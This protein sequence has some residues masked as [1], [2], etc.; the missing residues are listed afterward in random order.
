ML[1]MRTFPLFAICISLGARAAETNGSPTKPSSAP[2]VGPGDTRVIAE[3][4]FYADDIHGEHCHLYQRTNDMEFRAIGVVFRIISPA[5]YAGKV[6]TMHDDGRVAYLFF[7]I[8]NRYEL[9][10][11]SEDIGK[12]NFAACSPGPFRRADVK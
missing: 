8:S 1:A 4:Q 11:K 10:V 3:A 9:L 5:E 12:F 2:L 7:T 6:Y